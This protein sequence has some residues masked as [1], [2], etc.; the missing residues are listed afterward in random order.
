MQINPTMDLNEL[1]ARTQN[2][3]VIGELEVL[4][5]LLNA[6]E[7]TTTEEIPESTWLYLLEEASY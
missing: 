7:F 1:N 2:A 4:R 5:D 6:T 3:L